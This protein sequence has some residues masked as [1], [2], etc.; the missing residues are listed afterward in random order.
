MMLWFRLNV[1][2]VASLPAITT[3]NPLHFRETMPLPIYNRL[4]RPLS[5]V[6]PIV[7]VFQN[8]ISQPLKLDVFIQIS[9]HP[10]IIA[11]CGPPLPSSSTTWIYTSH[12]NSSSSSNCNNEQTVFFRRRHHHR[13]RSLIHF[14]FPQFVKLKKNYNNDI[15]TGTHTENTQIHCLEAM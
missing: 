13:H 11:I 1:N 5:Q 7:G 6:R 4:W 3:A 12:L 14:Q 15:C 2:V 10:H 9:S 8:L